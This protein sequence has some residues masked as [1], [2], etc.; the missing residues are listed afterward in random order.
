MSKTIDQPKDK[1]SGSTDCS[2][3]RGVSSHRLKPNAGNPREVA[4]MDQWDYENE[5]D[6]RDMLSALMTESCDKDDPDRVTGF[7]DVLGQHY[8]RP[9][10]PTTLRDRIV[11]ATVI[12]WLGSN[13]GMSFVE[14]ALARVGYKVVRK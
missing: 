10:G 7:G 13:V 5:G 3:V 11:A 8:K 6:S 4:F 1:R 2:K 14:M 9:L 12:Q